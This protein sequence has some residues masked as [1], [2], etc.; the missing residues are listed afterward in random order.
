MA[1]K[2]KMGGRKATAEFWAAQFAGW[3][4][5]VM[6]W[7]RIARD[8]EAEYEAERGVRSK[9]EDDGRVRLSLF[10]RTIQTILDYLHGEVAKVDV[11]RDHLDP[12]DDAAR[13]T[14][15]L[16]E[17]MVKSDDRMTPAIKSALLD[18]LVVGTGWCRVLYRENPED[19]IVE[20]VNWR[21]VRWSYARTYKELDWVA[22]RA[23]LTRP[24]AEARFGKDKVKDCGVVFEKQAL[25]E[26]EESQS[27]YDETAEAKAAVWEI[28]CK[29]SKSVYWWS[30]GATA[31]LDARP[32]PLGL[33]G[34]YPCPQ[35]MMRGLS[36]KKFIPNPMWKHH[37]HLY[38]EVNELENRTSALTRDVRNIGLFDKTLGTELNNLLGSNDAGGVL[39]PIENMLAQGADNQAR[40]LI[41]WVP[42]DVT[43]QALQTVAGQK[44]ERMEEI[45]DITGTNE[46]MRGGQTDPRETA[47]AAG[48]KAKMG[49]V[50]IR[51]LQ[52]LFA[53]FAS[54]LAA[55]RIE[56]AGRL[57]DDATILKQS[58]ATGMVTQQEIESGLLTAALALIR[59]P[60]NQWRI[61]I[62]PEALAMEDIAEVR[63][64]RGEFLTAAAQFM[65]KAMAVGAQVPE[66]A[67]ELGQLLQYG[68]AGFRGG[69]EVESIVDAMVAKLEARAANPQQ[70]QNPEAIKAQ[71]EQMKAQM[72]IQLEQLKGQNRQAELAAEAK[73]KQAE[74]QAE[75]A[76]K[77][78]QELAQSAAAVKQADLESDTAVDEEK[79]KLE[80]QYAH[81]KRMADLEVDKAAR[82]AKAQAKYAPKTSGGF[83]GSG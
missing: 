71:A 55:L 35:P 56:V 67:P 45:N 74:I 33:K 59:D 37:K 58:N 50:S 60:E 75:S 64:E 79:Q 80:L 61:N 36:N 52:S 24:E 40:R 82:I 41:E 5:R 26:K 77:Q 31:L 72:A 4:K 70:G 76:E 51:A 47:T 21:D 19:C 73:N 69:Q 18:Y 12:R 22:F 9:D 28:W 25:V 57:F 23:Y 83:E 10:N 14:S 54:D 62:K 68:L 38:N 11:S 20:Y 78:Q 48:L 43:V 8:A 34:F 42:L 27:G 44:R 81:A 7:M 3:D 30:E 39:V 6:R 66:I 46:I 29:S 17:R 2:Q 1:D 13:L 65:E 32:D 53:K 63:A 49:S 16:L 15:T